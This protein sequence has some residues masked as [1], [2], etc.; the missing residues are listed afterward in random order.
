MKTKN[1]FSFTQH[2]NGRD[3]KKIKKYIKNNGETYGDLHYLTF[4]GLDGKVYSLMCTW[5]ARMHE[6]TTFYNMDNVDNSGLPTNCYG[7]GSI[8]QLMKDNESILEKLLELVQ[9]KSVKIA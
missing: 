1:Y 9:I 7:L 2:V 4:T 6:I 3:F 8:N 5:Y